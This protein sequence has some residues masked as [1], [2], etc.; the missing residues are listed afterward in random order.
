MNFCAH[1]LGV[2]DTLM[3][4]RVL[5]VVLGRVLEGP[6]VVSLMAPMASSGAREARV[7]CAPGRGSSALFLTY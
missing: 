1:L 6:G 5:K 4:M 7:T 3:M 2:T